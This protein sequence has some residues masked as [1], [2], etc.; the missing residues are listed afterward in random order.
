VGTKY[1]R[2]AY[3]VQRQ[4]ATSVDIRA[5]QKKERQGLQSRV[6]ENAS[7]PLTNGKISL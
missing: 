6:G 4:A 3:G 7:R 5:L 2:E 1:Q